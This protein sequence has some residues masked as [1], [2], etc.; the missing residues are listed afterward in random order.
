VI[1]FCRLCAPHPKMSRTDWERAYLIAW[2]T[3]YTM[4]HMETVLRRLIAKK[5]PASNAIV[6]MTWFMGSIHLEK[7]HPLES[8]LLRLKFRRDRRP[9]LPIAPVWKFY[10]TYWVETMVKMARWAALY[11]RLRSTYLRIKKDPKRF[12]YMDL[13]LTP[14]TDHDVDDLEM[15]H[16]P[17]APAFVAQEQRRQ[18]SHE[19]A[20]VA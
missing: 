5:G 11:R 8:G 18:H 2:E 19:H 14:V 1:L 9:G 4:E 17:S 13:A 3:Y 20:A 12:K 7:I 15:F 10:P 6:L 16:T